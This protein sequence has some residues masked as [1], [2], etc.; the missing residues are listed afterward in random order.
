MQAK[1]DAEERE[2]KAAEAAA[3]AER[4]KAEAALKAAQDEAERKDSRDDAG[5]E[6]PGTTAGLRGRDLILKRW[7]W[8]A[9]AVA[10][11]NVRCLTCTSRRTSSGAI[12]SRNHCG[13]VNPHHTC[14]LARVN[15]TANRN[16]A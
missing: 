10:P 5:A 16:N 4:A 8:T 11:I 13:R 7:R 9:H 6:P 12:S 3:A 15:S 1:R 2:R 14:S